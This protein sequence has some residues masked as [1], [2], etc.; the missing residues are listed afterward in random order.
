MA[1]LTKQEKGKKT[2]YYL[3]ENIPL[4]NGMRKQIRKYI[5]SK[6]P[7]ETKL[8]V[9]M[10]QFEENIET[11]KIKLHGHHYLTGGEITEIAHI[12][13]EF[14]KRYNRQNKTV[15]EQFDQNFVMAFV[16]NTNS[17]EGSTLSPKEV[18]L[19]LG[20]DIAPNKP[21]DDV[22][23]AKAAQKSLEFIKHA[24][25]ELSGELLLKIH[26]MYFRST[27]PDIAGIYKTHQNR[28][29]GSSFETT[30]P[31]FVLTDMKN[32]FREYSKLEKELHPLEL[33]AWAHWKLVKIH[34]FQDGNVRTARIIMNY[35]LH[36]NGY[37]MIDIKTREKQQYFSALEKCHYNNNARALAI[38]LARRFKKQYKNALKD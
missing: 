7:T 25:E 35:V 9:L 27:K 19:L 14:R 34:P 32:Y 15:Q 8:Q 23:E 4:G 2:Y 16:Y 26:G 28:V 11:E 12:N 24:K 13:N 18:E 20:G 29:T 5:G 37:A 31:A 38:W 30:P 6:R 10:A 21:F 1:Y 22:L 3:A 17:I 36:K 33:A